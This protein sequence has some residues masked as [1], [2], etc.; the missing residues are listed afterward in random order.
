[1]KIVVVGPGAM[2]CLF[3]AFLLDVRIGEIWLLDKNP[4]RTK[5]IQKHGIE[6]TGLSN[7]YIPSKEVKIT[8][9]PEKI[10]I[11]DLIIIFVKSYDTKDAIKS[12][13]ECIGKDTSILT[14]QNGL[15]NLKTIKEYLISQPPIKS[16]VNLS[17]SN[18]FA[19]ITSLGATYLGYGRVKHAGIGETIISSEFGVGSWE[20]EVGRLRRAQS[21]RWK[22]KD[23][24]R[25]FNSAGIETKISNNLDG[26]LWSKLVLN[27]AINPLG[28][29]TFRRNGDLIENSYL[30]KL[31]CAVAEESA[32][33]AKKSAIKLLYKNPSK[34][35]IEVCKLTAKNY[36]SMLQDI[37]NNKK[38]E[39]DYINGAIIKHAKKLKLATPLNNLL[40]LYIKRFS[41]VMET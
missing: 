19:G 41:K 3:T 22:L 38:T 25:I 10:G 6:I 20:L 31:L 18:L 7:I 4:L 8:T 15:N 35:V 29:I 17:I 36:N 33:V 5:F 12:V 11:A 30:K 40:Y 21:S 37:L 26:L 34:K 23:I 27:S 39:I 13:L 28:T 24:Y 2:G 32:K 9:K 14:L 16:G 1:M